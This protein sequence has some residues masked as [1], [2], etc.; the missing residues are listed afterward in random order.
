MAP[1]GE[2]EAVAD[3]KYGAAEVAGEAFVAATDGDYARVEAPRK[4]ISCRV[5]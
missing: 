1:D 2:D 4:S 3:V 5:L